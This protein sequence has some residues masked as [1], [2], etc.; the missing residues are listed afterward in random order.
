MINTQKTT[1][2]KHTDA[3]IDACMVFCTDQHSRAE[4]HAANKIIMALQ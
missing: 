2:R 4:H 1:V 3:A